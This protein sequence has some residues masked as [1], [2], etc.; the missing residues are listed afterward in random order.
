[1]T[2]AITTLRATIANDLANAGVW[3]T[4][5]SVPEILTA[6]SVVIEADNPYISS[7]NNEYSSI[8]P[9]ANFK[10]LLLLPM[11]DNEGNMA[12]METFMLAVFLK[13]EASSLAFK[14]GDFSA[15]SVI[16]VAGSDLLMSEI[17]ISTLTTWS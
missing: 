10:I 17:S 5:K 6:N 1:M 14:I 12:G 9:M 7:T 16:T 3:D 13:L 2:N 8:G 4:Y 11:R 15:P